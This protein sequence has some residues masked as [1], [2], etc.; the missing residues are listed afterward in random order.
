MPNLRVV[1]YNI[2]YGLGLD[3]RVDLKRWTGHK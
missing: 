3:D 2:R 1:T